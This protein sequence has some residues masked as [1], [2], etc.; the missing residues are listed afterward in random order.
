MSCTFAR[1]KLFSVSDINK[2]PKA[3]SLLMIEHHQNITLVLFESKQIILLLKYKKNICSLITLIFSFDLPFTWLQQLLYKWKKIQNKQLFYTQ[4]SN[5]S[6]SSIY[7]QAHDYSSFLHQLE[8]NILVKQSI[9][10][11]QNTILNLT[12]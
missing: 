2:M 8:R 3:F 10:V 5:G 4:I 11:K 6:F 7:S 9:W 12:G 1:K